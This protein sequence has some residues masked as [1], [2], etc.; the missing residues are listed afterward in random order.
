MMYMFSKAW[1][2]TCAA[3]NPTEVFMSNMITLPLDGKKTVHANN[4]LYDLVGEEMEEFR[5]QLS[6]TPTPT[7]KELV[8][9]ISAPEG[10]RMAEGRDFNQEGSELFDCEGDFLEDEE[11]Q[12][13][14]EMISETEFDAEDEENHED[15]NNDDHI[16]VLDTSAQEL[17]NNSQVSSKTLHACKNSVHF[18]VVHLIT[19]FFSIPIPLSA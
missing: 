11:F 18:S 14:E 12:E 10:V 2:G 17:N 13:E 9:N 19:K 15:N 7:F 1:E 4:K 6:Q 3:I 8:S 5:I 16:E